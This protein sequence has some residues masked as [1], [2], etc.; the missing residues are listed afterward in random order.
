MIHSCRAHAIGNESLRGGFRLLR[1]ESPQIAREVVPGQFIMLRGLG[2]DWPYLGRPFSIY[3]SDAES[4]VEIVYEVVGRATSI[5]AR[6]RG[7]DYD[8]LGPL[9]RGFALPVHKRSLA[10]AGGVGLPPVAYY[11][12]KYVGL[13]DKVVL[14]I[15][16]R[17]NAE[18]LVPVGL[19]AQGVD[20]RP[21]TEDGS[22][23]SRGTAVDGLVKALGEMG[24]GAGL[25]VIACGPR[26]M[27]ARVASVCDGAGMGCEVSVEQVMACGLGDCLGCAVPQRGGGYLHA[28]SD[29]PV[30]EAASID[31]QRWS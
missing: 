9:G 15:G 12:Q 23:G 20:I 3:S 4:V 11:C 1:L 17:T 26:Q 28:C 6:T 10:V 24:D 13:L 29:G 18:I 2:A 14:V 27:L 21:Y 22:K 31:W 16:A 8:V 5:M 19:V 7:G 30:L 25:H